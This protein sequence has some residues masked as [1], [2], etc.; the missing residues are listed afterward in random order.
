LR[1]FFDGQEPRWTHALAGDELIPRREIVGTAVARLKSPSATTLVLLVAAGGEGKSLVLR[2]AVVDL[3]EAGCRVLWREDDGVLVP[4]AVAALPNDRPWV[5]A[6]DDGEIVGE[7]LEDALKKLHA[8]GRQDV[9]WLIGARDT[10]WRAHFG[11]G[12]REPSWS[13]LAS[14]WPRADNKARSQA[15]ALNE[16][17]A[18]KV[19]AAW[20]RAGTLGALEAVPEADRVRALLTA[21]RQNTGVSN[22]TFFG[23]VLE[24]RF[25]AEGL[26]AHLQTSIQHLGDPDHAIGSGCTLRDAFLYAA[27]VEAVGIDGVDLKVVAE[28]VGVE[29]QKRRPE[30]LHRLGQEA[31]TSGGGDALRTRAPAIARVAVQLVEE[32]RIDDDLEEIY[33]S[34]VRVTGELGRDGDAGKTHGAIMNCGPRLARELRKLG[35]DEARANHI[36]R[37]AAATAIDVEP[38]LLVCLVTQ[39]NTFRSTKD[40]GRGAEILRQALATPDAFDDWNQYVR[41]ALYE[42]GVCEG[43]ASRLI[44]GLWLT[45]LSLADGPNMGRVTKDRAK[46]SLAGLGAACL[47]IAKPRT[48]DEPLGK[49]LRATSVLGPRATPKRDG[50]TSGYFKRHGEKANQLKVRRCSDEDALQWMAA[51][52]SHAEQLVDD[53]E[54]QGIAMALVHSPLSFNQLRQTLGLRASSEGRSTGGS[55]STSTH[56]RPQAARRQ[57]PSQDSPGAATTPTTAQSR[58][59]MNTPPRD[60]IAI[61]AQ[62]YP[63]V[64]DARAVWVRAGGS[65]GDVENNPRPRDL[66]QARWGRSIRGASVR[67]AALLRAALDDLPNNTVI[68]GQLRTI[69]GTRALEAASRLVEAIEANENPMDREGTLELL[70]EW[71][72]VDEVESFAAICPALEGRIDE[73]RRSELRE[74]LTAIGEEVQSGAL[75][76]LIK[77]GTAAAVQTLLSA[78]SAT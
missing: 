38:N 49:L 32:G 60:L 70:A 65:T 29:R 41:S 66:W 4:D 17:D 47:E 45:G 8:A 11:R 19:V 5:L 55:V 46:R 14:L 62:E 48:L 18:T 69:A 67:P 54:L 9:H 1:L 73:E 13:L 39:A 75:T 44:S 21:A 57:A 20:K 53:L 34:L 63:D 2:Q 78:L 31:V 23:A 40:P 35:V 6:S 27:A 16:S 61:L 12:R 64:R 56:C 76:G 26:R 25:G 77:A 33:K 43:Q 36:A 10:D 68:I 24:E 3:V 52:V 30:I 59:P 22:G 15:L 7:E 37:A 72:V 50:R 51:A 28:L 42:L 71:Q 58:T 74:T